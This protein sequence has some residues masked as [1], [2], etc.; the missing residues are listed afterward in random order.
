M[1]RDTRNLIH[2]KQELIKIKK[3]TPLRSELSEGIP[4]FRR[5]NEG[6][7]QFIKYNNE[8]YSTLWTDVSTLE[9]EY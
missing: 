9:I 2:K 7:Q 4:V 6:L 5:T 3:G 1:D 8:I